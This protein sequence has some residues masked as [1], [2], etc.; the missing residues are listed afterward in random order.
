MEFLGYCPY[1]D[2]RSLGDRLRLHRMHRGLSYRAL[3]KML[4]IDPGSL[5]RWE[6]GERRPDRRSQGVIERFL[7]DAD[8][9]AGRCRSGVVLRVAGSLPAVSCFVYILQGDRLDLCYSAQNKKPG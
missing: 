3:G 1:Q 4:G 5:S 9:L 2:A 7:T 6:A 8:P